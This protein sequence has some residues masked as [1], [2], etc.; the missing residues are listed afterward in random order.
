[1]SLTPSPIFAVP[2][3]SCAD[4]LAPVSAQQY[5]C[6]ACGSQYRMNVGYLEPIAAPGSTAERP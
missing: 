6:P 4:E 3:P 2:C 5:R 1:M